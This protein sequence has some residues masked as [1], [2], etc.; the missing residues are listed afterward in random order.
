MSSMP[1]PEPGP[2]PLRLLVTGSRGW[3]EFKETLEVVEGALWDW[4]IDHEHTSAHPLDPLP[5]LVVGDCKTGVDHIAERFWRS[6]GLPV[7]RHRAN[8]TAYGRSAGPKRNREMVESGVDS[9][10]AFPRGMSRGTRGCLQIA[11]Q[12]GVPSQVFEG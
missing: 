7:E 10:L 2:Q 4:L 12:A 5:V 9:C 8:W 1:S 3:P 11:V 6:M